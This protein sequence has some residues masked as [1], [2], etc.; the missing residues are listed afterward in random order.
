MGIMSVMV[1]AVSMMFTPISA[2]VS[3]MQRDTYADL[4]VEQTFNYVRS[5]LAVSRKSQ[6]Y[7]LSTANMIGPYV[8]LNDANNKK[9]TRA[10]LITDEGRVYSSFSMAANSAA[11]VGAI[12]ENVYKPENAVFNDSFYQQ[13][14]KGKNINE[15][16]FRYTF[17]KTGTGA[18]K[19]LKMKSSVTNFPWNRLDAA[20]PTE[21]ANVTSTAKIKRLS[22]DRFTTMQILGA[23]GT[24]FF[25][26]TTTLTSQYES[27]NNGVS[28]NSKTINGIIIIYGR[29]F[30]PQPATST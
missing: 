14:A 13:T 28:V 5:Q 30:A 12:A 17:E 2:L 18:T 29:D 22:P 24:E 25:P 21:P 11:T 6:I 19:S 20:H 1:W 27:V 9:Y 16:Y 10:I 4:V 26:D 3:D 23:P 15:K 8:V 7:Q